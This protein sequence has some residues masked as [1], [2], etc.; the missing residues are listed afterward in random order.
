[1]LLRTPPPR[2]VRACARTA[3]VPRPGAYPARRSTSL[4]RSPG[5]VAE[6]A[7][8]QDSGS[9]VRKDVGVQVP[10]RPLLLTDPVLWEMVHQLVRAADALE[11][12]ESDADSKRDLG[13]STA[14]RQ[15]SDLGHDSE[16]SRW[17]W[18]GARLDG[19]ARLALPTEAR[20]ALRVPRRRRRGSRLD[21]RHGPR[22]GLPRHMPRSP[23]A[24]RPSGSTPVNLTPSARRVRP[25]P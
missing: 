25:R 15:L 23:R 12:R 16:P 6:L 3:A 17:V 18:G 20:V 19:K 21:Q 2:G 24:H 13:T 11:A 14:L 5:R 10:P 9:C 8:A 1:M 7:D 4:V 22:M